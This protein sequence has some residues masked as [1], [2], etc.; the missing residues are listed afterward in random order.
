M[1]KLISIYNNPQRGYVFCA[2]TTILNKK[3]HTNVRPIIMLPLEEISEEN[4]GKCIRETIELAKMQDQLTR[5]KKNYI[6]FGKMQVIKHLVDFQ[7]NISA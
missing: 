2:S 3:L 6:S 1:E 4:I 7:K 5:K